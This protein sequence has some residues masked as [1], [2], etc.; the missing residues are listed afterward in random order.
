MTLDRNNMNW[1]SEGKWAGRRGLIMDMR[2]V[3]LKGNRLKELTIEWRGK[4]GSEDWAS[5]QAKLRAAVRRGMYGSLGHGVET[6]VIRMKV[7][8][9]ET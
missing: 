2:P 1:D 6:E 8:T 4:T 3:I 7:K 9:K 5:F